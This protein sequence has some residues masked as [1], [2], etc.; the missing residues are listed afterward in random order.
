MRPA[1]PGSGCGL[2][3]R[4]DPAGRPRAGDGDRGQGVRH[5][6]G[7]GGVEATGAEAVIPPN[8]NRVDPREFDAVLYRE[9]NAVERCVSLFKP[10]RRVATRYEKTARNFLGMVLFAAITIWLR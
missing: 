8:K 6:R 5:G 3:P 9:R 4:P 7:G 10:F 2:H 1:E